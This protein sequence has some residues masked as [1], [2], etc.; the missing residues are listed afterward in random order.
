MHL[1]EFLTRVHA[2][3]TP[4]TYLEVGVQHGT[5]LYLASSADKAWGVDP[6]P[7]TS[8]QRNQTIFPLTSDIFFSEVEM[9]RGTRSNPDAYKLGKVDLGFIDGLHHYEQAL[10]DFENMEKYV[11][12]KSVIIF[13]DVLPRNNQE[14]QRD[15]CPG[16]WTGDV[17]KVTQILLRFRPEL[18]IVEVNTQ[19]T[20]TLVV[21]DFLDLPP[22]TDWETITKAAMEEYMGITEVPAGV[23]NR[24]FAIEPEDI[25][26]E[27]KG[28][29][30]E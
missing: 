14:A 24:D 3:V 9:N 28:F 6:R 30:S 17:W 15:Q 22:T 21:W 11:T 20:G 8:A 29:I 5:S 4:D 7:L 18:Y 10:R 25:L 2:V 26:K 19:P 13:D 23:L 12:R 1:H 16:D 27:L